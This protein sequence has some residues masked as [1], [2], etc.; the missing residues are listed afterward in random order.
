MKQK[1]YELFVSRT[2]TIFMPNQAEHVSAEEMWRWGG[3]MLSHKLCQ[4]KNAHSSA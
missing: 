3:K 1:Q 2:S 4:D